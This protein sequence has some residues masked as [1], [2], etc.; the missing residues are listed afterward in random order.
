MPLLFEK[1]LINVELYMPETQIEEEDEQST[2][3][4]E[5]SDQPTEYA[6]EE[7]G[8]KLTTTED[9]VTFYF[10]GRRGANA[11]VVKIVFVEEENMYMVWFEEEE[12]MCHVL[13]T[14]VFMVVFYMYKNS[15]DFPAV[16]N[17]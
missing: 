17:K 2:G 6:I 5:I 3:D 13:I 15:S 8:T 4:Q 12:G 11:D 14:T 7:R 9:A 1:K 10:E 16:I